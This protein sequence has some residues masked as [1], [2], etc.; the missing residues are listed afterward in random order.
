MRFIIKDLHISS[1]AQ[2]I[3]EL[4]ADNE[5]YYKASFEFDEPWKGLIKTA[6]FIC[7]EGYF[8]AILD[9]NDTCVIPCEVLHCTGIL[10]VGVYAGTYGESLLTTTP[11][12]M[13]V[14]NSILTES[15]TGIP[16][17]PDEALYLEILDKCDEAVTV[18]R[19]VEE[20]ANKGEFNGKPGPV[21]PKGDAGAVKFIPVVDRT[22]EEIPADKIDESAIYLVPSANTE[23]N[24]TFD[25][26]VFIDGVPEIIGN[27]SVA[28]N[29]DD[30]V[31]KT[32]Y[33]QH[34]KTGLVYTPGWSALEIVNATGAI[35]L[36]AAE[37]KHIDERSSQRAIKPSKLDYAIKS[38]LT[39]NAE[40]W[41][42]EEKAA[43]RELVGATEEPETVTYS[44]AI[45]GRAR[46][47][48]GDDNIW[49]QVDAGNGLAIY[50]GKV[51]GVNG[52]TKDAIKA[53]NTTRKPICTNLLDYAVKVGLTT[54]T[55]TLTEE[56]KA[57]ALEWLGVNAL[58][59]D[60]ETALDSIIAI[61][62]RTIA[63]QESLIG[64][65]VE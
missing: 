48:F 59:G 14:V 24:N 26:Y 65:D 55:E 8:D 58:V 18:A 31:K 45:L 1:D 63:L 9:D 25:E 49:V 35:D 4:I 34:T 40:E 17:D 43:A 19:S 15:G 54:N 36:K 39:A 41:T 60:I 22:L 11:A 21:G 44:D 37:N 53:K 64:G 33:A 32:D 16:K 46:G 10:K 57:N 62:E 42:E 13:R 6:R 52:A 2:G 50:N 38:G 61:Q 3:L 56:E 29:L 12:I 5:G 27:A 7:R 23:D 30:Y 47:Y 51:L 28:V 20:R